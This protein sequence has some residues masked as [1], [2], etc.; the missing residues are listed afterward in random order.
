MFVFQLTGDRTEGIRR[1]GFL[2]TR[3]WSRVFLRISNNNLPA[4]ITTQHGTMLHT[5]TQ[6]STHVNKSVDIDTVLGVHS[7]R[8]HAGLDNIVPWL[9]Q[10]RKQS[11]Q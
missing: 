5:T 3:A 11:S 7:R 9:D 1:G 4:L 2:E 8:C 6:H 10:V